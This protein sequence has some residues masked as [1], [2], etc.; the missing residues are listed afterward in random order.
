MVCHISAYC[1]SDC[2]AYYMS[3]CIAL[4]K[5]ETHKPEL[6]TTKKSCSFPAT[7][8]IQIQLPPSGHVVQTHSKS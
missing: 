2:I 5:V 6:E 3:F 1:K 4:R 8:E 7:T